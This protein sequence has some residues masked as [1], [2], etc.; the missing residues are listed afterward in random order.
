MSL[1]NCTKRLNNNNCTQYFPE[2]TLRSNNSNNSFYEIN[3]TPIS[4]PE[5]TV[6][7]G[8]IKTTIF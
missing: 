5:M 6:K 8:K 4:K 3:S 7:K 2:N 1:G